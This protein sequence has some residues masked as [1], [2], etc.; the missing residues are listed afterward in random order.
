VARLVA[1]ARAWRVRA[2][3]RRRPAR[4]FRSGT[5]R[6][7][8]RGCRSWDR[9]RWPA[10]TRRSRARRGRRARRP[11]REG[12]CLGG[13]AGLDGAPVQLDGGAEVS[14]AVPLEAAPPQLECLARASWCGHAFILAGLASSRQ[15]GDDLAVLVLSERAQR[16]VRTL[17]REPLGRSI[18][19][20]ANLSRSDP[21]RLRE[22]VGC[23]RSA[24]GW[25]EAASLPEPWRAHA[26]A[27]VTALRVPGGAGSETPTGSANSSVVPVVVVA[28][29]AIRI[30]DVEDEVVRRW[31]A[32]T[33]RY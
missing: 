26:D 10:C 18:W 12:V 33:L 13:G 2:R 19:R 21:V 31:P 7:R 5:R 17:P 4:P 16:L 32:A 28:R 30:H 11:S 25:I 9:P 14:S 29:V 22:F 3:A 6:C 8:C 23:W 1:A 27:G 24:L 15:H 20:S